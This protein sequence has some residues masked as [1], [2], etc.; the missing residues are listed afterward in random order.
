MPKKSR[1]QTRVP[2]KRRFLVRLWRRTHYYDQRRC[3]DLVIFLQYVTQI[4]PAKKNKKQGFLAQNSILQK[5]SRNIPDTVKINPEPLNK[6]SKPERKKLEKTKSMGKSGFRKVLERIEG[7]ASPAPQ[8]KL[9]KFAMLRKKSGFKFSKVKSNEDVLNS[10]EGSETMM[11]QKAKL[12]KM[13]EALENKLGKPVNLSESPPKPSISPVGKK[14]VVDPL[15]RTIKRFLQF[16][17]KTRDSTRK[18]LLEKILEEDTFKAVCPPLK[19]DQGHSRNAVLSP[20]TNERKRKGSFNVFN[21]ITSLKKTPNTPPV[22]FNKKEEIEV[23]DKLRSVSRA[24]YALDITY[25]HI[26]TFINCKK[27]IVGTGQIHKLLED[28]RACT[29]AYASVKYI[30]DLTVKLIQ[31][32]E[33]K[34]KV[35]QEINLLSHYIERLQRKGSRP[36]LKQFQ[37]LHNDT[38]KEIVKPCIRSPQIKPFKEPREDLRKIALKNCL[39]YKQKPLPKQEVVPEF[40]PRSSQLSTQSNQSTTLTDSRKSI[41]LNEIKEILAAN[42]PALWNMYSEFGAS[43]SDRL[44]KKLRSYSLVLSRRKALDKTEDEEVMEAIFKNFVKPQRKAMSFTLLQEAHID[45]RLNTSCD[46]DYT[47]QNCYF[48]KTARIRCGSV[49]ARDHVSINSGNQ[50][51]RPV[52]IDDFEVIKGL[53][54]GAYGKV[55][56]AKKRSSGDYF[57][58]KI[59]DREKTVE[60]AQESYIRSEVSIMRSV[61]SDYIVKLYYSF[62]NDDYWFFV[63]EYMNGGDLGNLLQNCGP[64]EE[65]FSKLYLAEIVVALE[66]LHSMNVLHRDLKPENIL[67]DS[68]GHLKLTDF[69]LSKGKIEGM[70]RKW[71][72]N[73]CKE[74]SKG[75]LIMEDDSPSKDE[76]GRSLNFK[77]TNRK[78]I[79]TPHYVAPETITDNQY[80]NSS[81]WWAVGIIAFEMMVG[82]P[83]YHGEC[84]E[85]VFKSVMDGKRCVEMDVG[86]NDDQISPDAADLVNRL[87]EKDPEKR[88]GAKGAEEIKQHQFF[89][90]LNWSMLREEEAPFVPK[91]TDVTDTSY[92]GDKKPFIFAPSSISSST[93]VRKFYTTNRKPRISAIHEWLISTSEL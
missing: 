31:H 38:P 71:I 40:N 50:L 86:Y 14:Q 23:L 88:L 33:V 43:P 57:A 56:L 34:L 24:A 44:T 32:L 6:R 51:R 28:I 70:S 81:D 84:P 77:A 47:L 61:N 19:L 30:N 10:L 15:Q 91:T 8:Q 11:K 76:L 75:E 82:S 4:R 58:L 41:V 66:H 87:L 21:S 89:Q 20:R 60:K 7:K 2:S 35:V 83:P 45:E 52:T 1:V 42:K 48:G 12:Q 36:S 93:N 63:M 62:Q 27:K 90:G 46:L 16:E 85:E 3:K 80:T 49:A 22:L 72:K 64:I 29:K 18:V 25:S 39:F 54:S 53:S 9:S 55:C 74:E 67:I 37:H 92:F 73:Y 17:N 5:Y 13:K 78:I 26:C 69:G 68:T 79:G 65:K 59:I